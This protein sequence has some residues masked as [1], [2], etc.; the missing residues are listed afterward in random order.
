MN[1]RPYRY[2]FSAMHSLARP[3][4]AVLVGFSLSFPS[5]FAISI[6][7]DPSSVNEADVGGTNSQIAPPL[8]LDPNTVST[9]G[10]TV[11]NDPS[12]TNSPSVAVFRAETSVQ[13]IGTNSFARNVFVFTLSETVHYSFSGSFSGSVDS[14]GA[15]LVQNHSAR[16]ESSGVLGYEFTSFSVPAGSSF[17][18]VIDGAG[19]TTFGSLTG[20]LSPGT[21]TFTHFHQLVDPGPGTGT[22]TGNGVVELRLQA[23]PDT[24]S[25][26][27]LFGLGTFGVGALRRKLRR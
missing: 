20:T 17:N 6:T 25:T 26:L 15:P 5:A 7:V 13:P 14:S 16:L 27:A 24:G 10:G 19:D 2:Y 1:S 11:T 9:A 21:Y 4:I 8:W 3:T 18:D 23:V 12:F 22:G